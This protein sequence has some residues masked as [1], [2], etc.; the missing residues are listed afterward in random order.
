MPL[1]CTPRT[2][3]HDVSSARQEKGAKISKL[4]TPYYFVLHPT[5][6]KKNYILIFIVFYVICNVLYDMYLIMFTGQL[7]Q[8]AIIFI[9]NRNSDF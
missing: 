5:S 6:A 2:Y 1:I 9:K 8:Y 4:V 3:A 7:K